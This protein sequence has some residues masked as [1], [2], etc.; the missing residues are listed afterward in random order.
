MALLVALVPFVGTIP[1]TR[2]NGQRRIP[3]R[4]R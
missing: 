2:P 3:E 4:R 1:E